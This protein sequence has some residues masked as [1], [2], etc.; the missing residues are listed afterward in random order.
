MVAIILLLMIV[1]LVVLSAY[2]PQGEAQPAPFFTPVVR[3]Q[4]QWYLLGLALFFFVAYLDYNKLREWT[5]LLYLLILIALAGLFFTESVQR[6][7]RWYR[8]PF[9]K[10]SLQPSEPAKLVVVIALSW[11]LERER[12]ASY[13]LKTV[14]KALCI[15]ALPFA[16]IFKQ[17]DLGTSLIL[18]PITL[19]MFYL[20]DVHPP[21]VRAMTGF[22]LLGLALIGSLF[23]GLISKEQIRPYAIHFLKEYQFDRLDPRSHQQQAAATAIAMGGINGV[24]WRQSHYAAAG[25]LPTPYTDSV[26]PAF[27]EEFG[28]LGLLLLLGL[29]YALIYRCYRIA[30]F[31]KDPFGR[32]L[33]AGISTYL[34]VHLLINVGM[35]S[36]FLPITGVPL[37]LITYGGSSVLVT[38][39]ALGILQSIYT[40]R[41]MF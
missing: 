39:I 37:I 8:L 9:L 3:V 36:G 13:S 17:P 15:V 23:L 27:G 7:H 4:L 11:F 29:F 40:R 2:S 1:G 6:V 20:G 32:L 28:L 21:F 33:A 38:L 30:L 10:V 14:F 24:G 16:L 18:C 41:F 19:A 35:M 12:T 22:S 34:A 31:A 5:W 26:F 25:F